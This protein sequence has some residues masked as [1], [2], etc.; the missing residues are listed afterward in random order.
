MTVRRFALTLVE[1]TVVLVH[2]GSMVMEEKV[3]KVAILITP[4]S[5]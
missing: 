5:L 3:E 2:M 4:S 1:V